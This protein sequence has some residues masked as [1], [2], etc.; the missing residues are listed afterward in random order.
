MIIRVLVV[1]EVPA[2]MPRPA[3][4]PVES[5]GEDELHDYKV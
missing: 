2:P 3:R 4:A 5:I 1:P